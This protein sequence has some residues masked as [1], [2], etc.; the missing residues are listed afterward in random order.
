[1][2]EPALFLGGVVRSLGGQSDGVLLAAE[3]ASMEQTLFTAPSVFNF[4][5]PGYVIPGTDLLGPEFAIYDAASA[6]ARANAVNTLI[7]GG[8][9][10]AQANVAGATGT[11]IDLSS[12]ASTTDPVAM[13]AKLNLLLMQGSLS[14]QASTAILAAVKAQAAGNPLAAAR[15]AAYLILTSGQYQVER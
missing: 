14:S 11:T 2:R 3:A 6:L 9:A 10:K 13:I 15:T 1:M 4:Y 5:P 12:V 7:M 8:G